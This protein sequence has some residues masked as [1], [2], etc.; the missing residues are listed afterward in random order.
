MS[1][2]RENNTVFVGKK[3]TMNYV[4]ACL[5]LFQN[6]TVDITLKARGH[7]ISKAVD[8]AQIITKKFVPGVTVKS[9]DIA[10][11]QVKN[12]ESGVTSDVSSMEIHLS[13]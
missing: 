7:A 13:K 3:P 2:Q 10:T 5:T 8:A 11:E 12:M 9:V 1:S 6:G 4:L